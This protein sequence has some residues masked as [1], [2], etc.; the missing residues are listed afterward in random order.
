MKRVVVMQDGFIYRDVL[1]DQPSVTVGRNPECDIQIDNKV[2]SG[3]H[4]CITLA[5]ELS[6][7]DLGSTNGTMVNGVKIDQPTP[8]TFGK[9]ITIVRYQIYVLDGKKDEAGQAG[10]KTWKVETPRQ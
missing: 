6:V 5:P 9:M 2:V 1:T 4:L 10:E 7:E 3:V 8:L